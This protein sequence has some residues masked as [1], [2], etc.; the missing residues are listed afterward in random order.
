MSTRNRF[1]VRR[2]ET[3]RADG[4]KTIWSFSWNE[5]YQEKEK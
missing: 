3:S 1:A 4:Y 2:E 5:D